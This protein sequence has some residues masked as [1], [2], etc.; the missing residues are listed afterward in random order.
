MLYANKFNGAAAA[1][2][3]DNSSPSWRAFGIAAPAAA[4]RCGAARRNGRNAP[5]A[6][7]E[8]AANGRARRTP[9]SNTA[10][11]HRADI[12]SF[13]SPRRN[14][15]GRQREGERIAAGSPRTKPRQLRELARLCAGDNCVSTNLSTISRGAVPVRHS[16]FRR[17]IQLQGIAY[18]Q[19]GFVGVTAGAG[20]SGGPTLACASSAF[21]CASATS[22][23]FASTWLSSLFNLS[24][25]AVSLA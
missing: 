16:A 1:P 23:F 11:S 10:P 21:F 13:L 18:D 25:P 15:V 7:P 24:A 9:D 2:S 3:A 17:R 6:L 19:F 5:A 8:S 22:C 12:A 4:A 14:F 20:G